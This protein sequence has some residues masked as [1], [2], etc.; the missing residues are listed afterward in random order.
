MITMKTKL[1]ILLLASALKVPAQDFSFTTTPE[2][3]TSMAFYYDDKIINTE[4]KKNSTSVTAQF[5]GDKLIFFTPASI[6]VWNTDTKKQINQLT[7]DRLRVRLR[8]FPHLVSFTENGHSSGVL[9]QTDALYSNA[10]FVTTSLPDTLINF[11]PDAYYDVFMENLDNQHFHFWHM[12]G[13]Q[14]RD[15]FYDAAGNRFYYHRNEWARPF[16]IAYLNQGG[17]Y[18]WDDISKKKPTT[19]HLFSLENKAGGDVYFTDFTI[20]LNNMQLS[21]YEDE[22]RWYRKFAGGTGSFWGENLSSVNP[23]SLPHTRKNGY[24][25][26]S[27]AFEFPYIWLTY[28]TNDESK[29][30]GGDNNFVEINMLTNKIERHQ[31]TSEYSY[32]KVDNEK[33]FGY[34]NVWHMLA[35]LYADSLRKNITADAQS[36]T[37]SSTGSSETLFAEPSGYYSMKTTASGKVTVSTQDG[38]QYTLHLEA[39]QVLLSVAVN[40]A[41]DKMAV[42]IGK[43]ALSTGFK[44]V[45]GRFYFY[46][47]YYFLADLKSGAVSALT[48]EAK[49]KEQM[50]L[51][52]NSQKSAGNYFDPYK[53]KH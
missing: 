24:Y 18:R 45:K 11:N 25:L 27:S 46:D 36:L 4:L 49:Y 10:P 42:A 5:A 1:F 38:K 13:E 39:D 53:V 17:S 51:L 14:L 48:D 47:T 40:N 7:L 32:Y 30:T 52:K 35:S 2:A 9:F 28:S 43:K 12:A 23:I 29:E 6:T 41:G 16:S 34:R 37:I 26:W 21:L 33:V 22:S 19:A 50:D 44:T 20:M 15:Y 8:T 31:S 3:K